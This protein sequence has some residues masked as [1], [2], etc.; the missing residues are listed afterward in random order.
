MARLIKPLT[1]AQVNNAKPKDKPYKLFDGG[2]LFLLVTPAGGKHWKMKYR[3]ANGKEGLLSFGSY[4]ALSLE[5]ARRK[6]DDVRTQKVSGIDPGEARRK[7]KE[8]LKS[9]ARNTFGAISNAWVEVMESKVAPQSLAHYK[10]ILRRELIP[11]LGNIPITSIRPNDFLEVLRGIESRGN[12]PTCKKAKQICS[13]IMR[14]GIALGLVEIDP[15]PSINILLKT[16]KVV[17]FAATLDADKLGKILCAIDEYG[18]IRGCKTTKNA[19]KMMPYVFVRNAELRNAKW[20]DID[21]ESCEWRYNV[22]KTNTQHIVPLAPQ[23]ISIL[24]DSYEVY[25]DSEYVFPH[26]D[27]PNKPMTPTGLC[28]ALRHAGVRY[29]EMTIHGFRAVART[30]LEEILGERYDI[31][32]QQLAHRVRDPNGRAYNRTQHLDERKRMMIRWANYLDELKEKA[33]HNF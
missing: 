2:G 19:L 31:I 21:F 16:Q 4:P 6:R 1:A 5:Q 33:R 23:V 22:S 29:N 18:L 30:L 25:G 9:Q 24:K 28:C 8:E 3:Q 15:L 17:H 20:K 26:R 7:E 14:Y 13:S 11:T 32:E 12:I 10:G 27:D